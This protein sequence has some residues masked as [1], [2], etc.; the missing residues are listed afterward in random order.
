MGWGSITPEYVGDL[1]KIEGTHTE[2]KKGRFLSIMYY[3]RGRS[4]N[5]HLDFTA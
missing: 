4:N 3:H 1:I 2:E 5:L